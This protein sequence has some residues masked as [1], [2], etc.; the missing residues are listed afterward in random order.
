M[1]RHVFARCSVSLRAICHDLQLLGRQARQAESAFLYDLKRPCS[2][3]A[4]QAYSAES[5]RFAACDRCGTRSLRRRLLPHLEGRPGAGAYAAKTGLCTI[6]RYSLP[7]R[8]RRLSASVDGRWQRRRTDA[9]K[10]RIYSVRRSVV[11]AYDGLQSRGSTL[12]CACA[13]FTLARVD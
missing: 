9:R 1:D 13:W 10:L 5:Y 11:L 7:L 4:E 8:R 2:L 3:V 6:A 12:I